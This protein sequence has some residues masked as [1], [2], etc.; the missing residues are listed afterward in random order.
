MRLRSFTGKTMSEALAQVRLHLG[1]EAVIVATEEDDDGSVRVT[2]ALDQDVA[3]KPMPLEADVIDT[4][5]AVLSGH[6]LTADLTEKILTAA[7]PYAT[8]EP[9]VALANALAA[10]YPFRPVGT[11]N[12]RSRLLL[13]GPPGAGKTVTA[14]KL[15]A[16][17]VRA[18]GRVR[19]VSTDA[20]RAGAADQLAA[21]AKILRVPA[22]RAEDARD[23][24]TVLSAC[25]PDETL[26]IDTAGINPYSRTDREEINAL[27][28]A[29]AA[30]PVLVMPA[31][32]DSVD[33]VE[34][35]Q[36][37][38][39]HGCGR[40]ILTRIDIA[41]RL[42][43]ALAAADAVSLAFAEAGIAAAIAD[44][45]CPFTPAFLARLLLAAP[46]RT[47]RPSLANTR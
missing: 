2:A 47:R 9:V 11:E 16:R 42:V 10:L 28:C 5:D 43:S 19:L 21:F 6:G 35:A 17:A 8:H 3:A 33:A 18:G 45:L 30:E 37:F 27:I 7:L 31:G 40:I 24:H 34:M 15:A 14:A 29:S 32:S 39:E 12:K 20:A 22:E 26:F 1:D 23:L 46:V 41:R 13:V 36:I 38:A 25:D 4:L 44:G